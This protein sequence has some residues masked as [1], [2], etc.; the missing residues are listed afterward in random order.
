MRRLTFPLLR[1]IKS[2]T[3]VGVR[4]VN[5]RD[6]KNNDPPGG[7]IFTLETLSMCEGGVGGSREEGNNSSSNPL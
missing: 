6:N 4:R 3:R 1:I 5:K 2:I 7:H